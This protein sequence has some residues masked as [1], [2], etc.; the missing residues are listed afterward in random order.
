MSRL[1][2]LTDRTHEIVL[3]EE[4]ARTYEQLATHHLLI[5]SVVAVDLHPVDTCLRA[6]HHAEL[7]VDGVAPDIFLNGHKLIEEVAVVEIIVGHSILIGLCALLEKLL[8]VHFT[9]TDIE[10]AVEPVSINDSIAY[11]RDIADIILLALFKVDVDVDL[12]LVKRHYAVR[13]DLRVTVAKLVVFFENAVEV[14][15]IIVLHK[16]F[17]F[18]EIHYIAAFVGLFHRAFDLLVGKHLIARDIDL[19]NL[20]LVVFVHVDL[21]DHFVGSRQIFMKHDVDLGVAEAFFLVVGLDDHDGTVDDVL[22]HLIALIQLQTLLKIVFLAFFHALVIYARYLRL[23]SQAQSEPRLI[24][25]C[26]VDSDLHFA[27]QSLTPQAL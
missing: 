18:E 19:M 22:R 8:V 12:L 5:K 2:Y 3:A 20:E 6:L 9:G 27:E 7:Q 21:H 16:L 15:L 24:A 17:L 23:F 10:Y 4:F 14:I 25:G 11:P 13:K 1:G 26:L